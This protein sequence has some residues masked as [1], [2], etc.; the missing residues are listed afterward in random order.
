MDNCKIKDKIK[1]LGACML[2]FFFFISHAGA[3]EEGLVAYYSF[4]NDDG[5]VLHD[6]SGNKNNGTIYGAVQ[7]PGKSGKALEFDGSY[8]YADCGNKPTLAI[9]DSITVEAWIKP[10]SEYKNYGIVGNIGNVELKGYAL[11][12]RGSTNKYS[13]MLGDARTQ[14]YLDSD[15]PVDTNWHH[16]AGVRRDGINYIY[17]DGVRQNNTNNYSILPSTKNT[18]IG[19]FYADTVFANFKG[20]IDEVRIYNRALTDSEIKENA[21]PGDKIITG[22]FEKTQGMEEVAMQTDDLV[23][24][25]SPANVTSGEKIKIQVKYKN[26]P[27][28]G[29]KIKIILPN[30]EIVEETTDNQGILVTKLQAGESVITAEKN[31]MAQS[32]KITVKGGGFSYHWILILIILIIILILRYVIFK[33]R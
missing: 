1:N 22:D 32:T 21:K 7:R 16:I 33:R 19:R 2:I 24:I 15:V 20:K 17:V 13:F 14:I 4:D 11:I 9:M 5:D 30:G 3:S 10:G 23:I 31:G 29:A 8:D 28:P 25:T 26:E 6:L 27:V 12:T 18:N